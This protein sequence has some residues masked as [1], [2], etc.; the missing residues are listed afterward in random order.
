MRKTLF[1]LLSAVLACAFVTPPQAAS[2]KDD[3]KP[4]A[5]PYRLLRVAGRQWTLKR[6]PKPGN[7]GGDTFTTYHHFEVLNVWEDR[8]EYSQSTLDEGMK[9]VPGDV[10]VIKVDFKDDQLLFRDPIGF[11]KGKVEK[12]KTKAGTFECTVWSSLGREDGDAYIWRSNDFPGLIVKQDDRFGTREICEF[13]FVDGDPGYKAPAAKKNKKKKGG[14]DSDKIDPK[15]LFSSKGTTWALK[16][17]TE[18]GERGTK[19]IDVTQ[20][21]ITKVS[22]EECELEITKLT[23]LF[24]KIKGEEPETRII[25]FDDTFS[26][27]LEPKERSREERKELRITAVGLTECTVY[28]FKDEEG[29]EGRAW[30]DNEWPGLV[31]RRTIE[32]ENFKQLTEIVKFEE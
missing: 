31:V 26:D 25:K 9:A 18:R 2:A 12:V 4:E 29:R 14:A 19:T 32:G 1:L 20:Y 17:T 7:E 10:F 21:E 11:K 22:D 3:P 23:Q 24:E 30:Y 28:T 8:A 27:N 6:T 15:K 5:D 16:T 13:D